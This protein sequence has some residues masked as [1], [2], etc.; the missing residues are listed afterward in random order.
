MLSMHVLIVPQKLLSSIFA[1]VISPSK[2][3]A[4]PVP[5]PKGLYVP[6]YALYA[7]LGM[8]TSIPSTMIVFFATTPDFFSA[9]STGNEIRM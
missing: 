4:V 9:R 2:Y 5:V 6:L 1:L 8:D 7:P 3:S